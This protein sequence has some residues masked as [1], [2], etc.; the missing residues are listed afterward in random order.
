MR[1]SSGLALYGPT[2]ER[3][4]SRRSPSVKGDCPAESGQQGDAGVPG[5]QVTVG[6]VDTAVNEHQVLVNSVNEVNQTPTGQLPAREFGFNRVNRLHQFWLHNGLYDRCQIPANQV[7]TLTSLSL[8]VDITDSTDANLGLKLIAPGGES[9]YLVYEP[10]CWWR[11]HQCRG[12]PGS[13]VGVN[14][15]F[16]V[17]TTFTDSAARSI[18]DINASGGRGASAPY[19]GDYQVENDGFVADADGRNQRHS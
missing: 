3:N 13:N 5:G 10:E 18:V 4:A 12:I 2:T 8:T 11:E 7:A 6:W 9:I 15:G 14:N 17:G 19:V 16:L 1:Q